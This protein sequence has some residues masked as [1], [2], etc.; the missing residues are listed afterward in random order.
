M[1][2]ESGNSQAWGKRRVTAAGL[3][4][5]G[6]MVIAFLIALVAA[7]AAELSV[8]GTVLVIFLVGLA[9]VPIG[10]MLE[11]RGIAFYREDNC[12]DGDV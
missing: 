2:K 4:L 1:K 6:A 12:D 8:F 3:A 5:Y 9:F 11:S 10:Q 7:H